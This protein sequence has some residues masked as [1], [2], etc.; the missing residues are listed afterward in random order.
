MAQVDEALDLSVYEYIIWILD[1]SISIPIEMQL[2]LVHPTFSKS[3]AQLLDVAAAQLIQTGQVK[4]PLNVCAFS[5]GGPFASLM[6]S[7]RLKAIT[8]L[9]RLELN[10]ENLPSPYQNNP[11][12]IQNMMDVLNQLTMF[13]HYSEWNAYGSTRLLPPESRRIEYFPP[14]WIE[15]QYPGPAFGYRD[16]RGYLMA[17]PHKRG[18]DSW[19]KR[20]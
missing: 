10:L 14:G 9:E 17:F 18:E 7:D 8:L 13:G 3:T 15:V 16:F 12:L 11:G 5:G 19:R 1:H 20:T 4:Y 6:E 2:Q